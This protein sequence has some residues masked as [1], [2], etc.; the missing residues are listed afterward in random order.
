V[1]A[2]TQG[3]GISFGSESVKTLPW[4]ACGFTVPAGSNTT[5][6]P[7]PATA[8]DDSVLHIYSGYVGFQIY[9]PGFPPVVP[10]TRLFLND[11]FNLYQLDT[12][13]GDLLN[14]GAPVK[15]FTP[16]SDQE[17]FSPFIHSFKRAN[18]D[19]HTN[20]SSTVLYE[21]NDTTK[22]VD[23]A[24]PDLVLTFGQMGPGDSAMYFGSMSA[25]D[26]LSAA[27]NRT[28]SP[29]QQTSDV[30]KYSIGNAAKGAATALTS[31]ATVQR[32]LSLV[33]GF[34]NGKVV[35]G[36][37]DGFLLLP[38]PEISQGSSRDTQILLLDPATNNVTT[39]QLELVA[40]SYGQ[41]PL[42]Q[43]T[44]PD[45]DADRDG[46][47]D[48]DEANFYMT[49]PAK[50]DSDGDQIEDGVEVAT[51]TDPN[52]PND[53]AD[54]TDSD[55]DGVPDSSDPD[56]NSPDA[57]DDGYTDEY[58]LAM[59][60]DPQNPNDT[61]PLGDAD[62]NGN[63][64]FT[65]AVAIFNLFLGNFDPNDYGPAIWQDVNRD[66]KLDSVDGVILF[67]FYLGNVPHI[68]YP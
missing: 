16:A 31:V 5:L 21:P 3:P 8:V 53:P 2:P 1:P 30:Y 47:S 4:V 46:L 32:S 7:P 22:V 11:P 17:T 9:S 48:D 67:N 49:D 66:G 44:G 10:A 19:V 14:S 65:D 61:P 55:G 13:S 34:A 28:Y 35:I 54:K 60:Y 43:Q 41:Q 23:A 57:D 38:T 59:G 33:L 52:D 50:K 45:P 42:P 39:T 26:A 12:A 63:V 6:V 40:G 51:G 36:G 58:E 37:Q 25:A 20:V 68:P 24:D 29:V 15:E 18:G 56:P 62:E 27:V 64:D